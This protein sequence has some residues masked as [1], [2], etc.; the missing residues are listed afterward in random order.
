LCFAVTL[1]LF[2]RIWTFENRFSQVTGDFFLFR[3]RNQP[4]ES[5]MKMGI[6]RRKWLFLV[7]VVLVGGRVTEVIISAVIYARTSSKRDTFFP[8]TKELLLLLAARPKA[9]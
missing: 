9:K 6:T 5:I 1:F 2:C 7:S 8:P 4:V 3:D